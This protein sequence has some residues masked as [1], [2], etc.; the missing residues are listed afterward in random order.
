MRAINIFRLPAG[1]GAV[2]RL[3]LTAAAAPA[4]AVGSAQVGVVPCSETAL[5][6]AVDEANAAGAVT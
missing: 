3:L 5:V 1:S 6:N 4:D 2:G